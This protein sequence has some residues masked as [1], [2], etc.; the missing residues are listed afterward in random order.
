LPLTLGIAGNFLAD[1]SLALG[2]MAF[3]YPPAPS[4]A[5]PIRPAGLEL[6]TI[7]LL[8]HFDEYAFHSD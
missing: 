5:G 1:Q 7:P 6:P 3:D 8:L 4:Q 2:Q